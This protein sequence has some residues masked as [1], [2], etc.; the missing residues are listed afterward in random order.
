[1]MNYSFTP[2]QLKA[3]HRIL[4]GIQK[5]ST[6]VYMRDDWGICYTL[7]NQCPELSRDMATF[8]V[9]YYSRSWNEYS[10]DPNFP[11]PSDDPLLEHSSKFVR[12][13]DLWDKDTEYGKARYRLVDHLIKCIENDLNQG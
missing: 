11:V 13:Y 7:G 4:L 3:A 1:M 8:M 12:T 10:G 5:R 9:K 6:A 2:T